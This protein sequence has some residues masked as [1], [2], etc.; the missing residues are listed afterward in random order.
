M[1]PRVQLLSN[2]LELK[3]MFIRTNTLHELL[4]NLYFKSG[5][6]IAFQRF[7]IHLQK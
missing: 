5:E 7:K 1:T 3:R 2:I 4:N 6:H